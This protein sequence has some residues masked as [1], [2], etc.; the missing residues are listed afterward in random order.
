MKYKVIVRERDKLRGEN[1]TRKTHSKAEA[2]RI[3]NEARVLNKKYHVYGAEVKVVK[4]VEPAQRAHGVFGNGLFNGSSPLAPK[5]K[6][7]GGILSEL[8]Y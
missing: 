4:H 2:E 8:G 6:R 5:K 3:A 7:Q 1:Y